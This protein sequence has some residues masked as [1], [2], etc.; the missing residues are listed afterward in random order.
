[1]AI[2]NALPLEPARPI[3]RSR[4]IEG[5]SSTTDEISATEANWVE[6]QGRLHT[7]WPCT[8]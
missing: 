3:S 6:N 2:C 8:N 5:P 4:I 7:F 1:M